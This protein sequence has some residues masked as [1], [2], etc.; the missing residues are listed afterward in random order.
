MA[1]S[2]QEDCIIGDMIE[3]ICAVLRNGEWYQQKIIE[4]HLKMLQYD[5]KIVE[6][7]SKIVKNHPK[8]IEDD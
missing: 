6:T 7:H 1:S 4:Y 5:S 8:I 3:R 2:N